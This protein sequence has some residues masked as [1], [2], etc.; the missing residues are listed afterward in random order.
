MPSLSANK[1]L[2][3]R[4]LEQRPDSGPAV[5]AHTTADIIHDSKIQGFPVAVF[6][7]AM[8]NRKAI[9]VQTITKV[10]LLRILSYLH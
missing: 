9:V 5:S 2:V 10:R 1:K 4:S 7:V 3:I 8:Q 6:A